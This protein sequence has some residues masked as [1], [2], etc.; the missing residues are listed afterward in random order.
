MQIEMGC[1][2]RNSTSV[3]KIDD[4]RSARDRPIRSR[5]NDVDRF[6]TPDMRLREAP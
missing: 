6:S 4:L 5:G 3:A 1:Y 2:M